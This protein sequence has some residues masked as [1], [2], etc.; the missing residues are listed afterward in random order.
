MQLS[1]RASLAI[2]CLILVSE[3][4]ET[5][6]ITSEKIALSTG[7][8]PVAIRS[9][10]SALKKAGILNV[11]NGTGGTTLNMPPEEI[12][13]YRI[14]NAVKPQF[15]KTPIWNEPARAA[16]GNQDSMASERIKVLLRSLFLSLIPIVDDTITAPLVLNRKT[17]RAK[18][19]KS[20]VLLCEKHIAA[21]FAHAARKLISNFH[22][23]VNTN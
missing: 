22:R 9:I 13:V 4:G 6:K 1:I 12:T 20:C 16:C 7:T 19:L 15:C 8:N 17:I 3:F 10:M 5:D 18:F 14:C 23:Q 21:P 2:H 11:K